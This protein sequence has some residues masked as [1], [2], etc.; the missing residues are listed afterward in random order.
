MN[1][2]ALRDGETEMRIRTYLT[3][4]LLPL[5]LF[6]VATNAAE[7]MTFDT[8]EAAVQALVKASADG[9]Q[10]EML[11]VLGGDGKELVYSGDTVQDKAH[12]QRFVKA[13]NT[14]H[15]LVSKDDNTRIL[16]VGANDWPMPI[17]LVN[18]GGKWRFDTAAGKQEM[19]FRRIGHNELGAI[20]ACRG[21]I[22]A[23]KDY[24]ALGHDGLPAGI[25]ASRLMSDTGTENG[26]Y[27]ETKEDEP[28]S[29]AGPFLAKAGGEGY[30]AAA[31]SE[32]S[33]PYHGYLYRIL[34]AQGMAAKGG[35]KSYL[36]E[37]KLTGGVALVAYPAQ[38]E[39][40]GVMTFIINQRGVV[41]Q[42]DLGDKTPELAGAMTEYNP[43]STWT[44]VTDN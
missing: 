26:L 4:F 27:W 12:M 10:E 9:S 17:P 22:D 42:K 34:T 13:Y 41:Y 38:Y 37:G 18:D 14:K 43:D 39:V 2:K 19:L 36:T 33:Q 24:A 20:A 21:F 28:T 23:Q 44:K 32:E 35:A 40:S 3:M 25:Y 7:Q 5:L 16:Q 29:P 15:T 6:A 8:P 30:G 31:G 11:A 1:E